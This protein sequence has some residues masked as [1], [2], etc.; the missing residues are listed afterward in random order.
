MK[1]SHNFPPDLDNAFDDGDDSRHA[2]ELSEIKRED[3]TQPFTL[4]DNCDTQWECKRIQQCK[5]EIK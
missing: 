5:K 4:C 1:K 2:E 3:S